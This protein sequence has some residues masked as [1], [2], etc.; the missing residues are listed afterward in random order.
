MRIV[1]VA[2]STPGRIAAAIC[3][4]GAVVFILR[5]I[6]WHTVGHAIHECAAYFPAVLALEIMILACSTLSLR[7]LYGDAATRVP[8]RQYVRAALVGYAIQGLFPAGR[9]AAEAARATMLAKW[10]G[11]GRAGAAA[12]RMQAV[13]LL[14]NAV[15]SVPAAVATALLGAP[16]WLPIAIAANAAFTAALGVTVLLLGRHVRVGT[17]LGK[18]IKRVRSF[19]ADVDAVLER[20]PIVPMR[21]IGWEVAGRCVQVVQHGLLLYCISGVFGLGPSLSAEGIHL[22]GAAIGD[23][24]PAQ[25]GAIEG[26]FTLAA[27]ALSLSAASAV[28]IALIVHLAQLTWVIVGLVVPLVWPAA[29]RLLDRA[30]KRE[31]RVLA[32]LE[33]ERDE[34]GRG[35]Q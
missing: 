19:G 8:P 17:W 26:N 22:V 25:I 28:S 33:L 16:S 5:N 31:H 21:A 9:A 10:V 18:R 13:V 7:A 2:R 23:L 32:V 4:L 20:E 27:S 14:A 3:G 29:A 1:E 35:R 34:P 24:I 11:A 12:A 6:G 30:D 15:I